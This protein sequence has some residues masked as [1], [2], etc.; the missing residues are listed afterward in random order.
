M[1]AWERVVM[2]AGVQD[3]SEADLANVTQALCG[4]GFGFGPGQRRQEHGSQNGDDSNDN[5]KLDQ[6]EG[7]RKL[8]PLSNVSG[9]AAFTSRS[10]LQGESILHNKKRSNATGYLCLQKSER[11]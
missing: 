2:V 6:R 8:E 5:Q 10:V 1:R 9:D 11:S 4:L 7:D 3:Q